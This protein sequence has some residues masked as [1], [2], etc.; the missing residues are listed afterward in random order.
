MHFLFSPLAFVVLD[1]MAQDR[2]E[3]II[4]VLGDAGVGKSAFLSYVRSSL[5]AAQFAT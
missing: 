5:V 3:V 1:N 2:P 4:L